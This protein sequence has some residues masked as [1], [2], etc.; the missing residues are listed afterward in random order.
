MDSDPNV[1][2]DYRK[3]F[4]LFRQ[5]VDYFYLYELHSDVFENGTRFVLRQGEYYF[6]LGLK[7]TLRRITEKLVN[8]FAVR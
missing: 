8:L 6:G 2:T 5:H 4:V 7:K 1:R 3:Q